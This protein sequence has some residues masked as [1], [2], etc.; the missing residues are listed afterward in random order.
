MQTD[1]NSHRDIFKEYAQAELDF[2]EQ[3]TDV[4]FEVKERLRLK[5][6]KAFANAKMVS[7]G[8]EI[9]IPLSYKE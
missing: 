6:V 4:L 3:Q 5:A 1:D 8:E 2:I 9:R 7:G